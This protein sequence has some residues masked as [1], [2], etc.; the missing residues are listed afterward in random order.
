MAAYNIDKETLSQL[1]DPVQKKMNEA[2][3]R[4]L[5]ERL[6]DD[7][8]SDDIPLNEDTQP[9][10]EAVNYAL[11][12]F[13]DATGPL[14]VQLFQ[15]LHSPFSQF[16][17][18]VGH[19]D[20][21]NASNLIHP[22]LQNLSVIPTSRPDY[23]SKAAQKLDSELM[24]IR[25]RVATTE[26]DARQEQ[27][28]AADAFK[29]LANQQGDSVAKRANELL[30]E[31]D[32]LQ[33]STKEEQSKLVQDMAQL[34]DD[35]QERYGFTAEQVLGGAHELAATNEHNLAE[36]HG[37]WS[38]RSMWGAVAW[39]GL[40]QIIWLTPFAPDWEQWLDALRSV[41]I[42][43]S[44]VVIL[45]FIAKREG[46]VAFEHRER[47]EK[48]QSL[49]LQLKSWQ[50]YLNTLS[51]SVREELEKKITPRLFVGDTSAAV[52]SDS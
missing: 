13:G 40:A 42:I 9:I 38:R 46:R 17:Q 32:H 29:Q 24:E 27:R 35:L 12:I 21:G 34:L 10:F 45:L 4:D 11:M 33:S 39:A 44:P 2:G 37:K 6:L 1:P 41:P 51:E 30:G 23:S 14:T 25:Q 22:L 18:Y 48:L 8:N 36:L 19:R 50:P 5:L 26:S 15:N 7:L 20:W 31:F 47:H 43:G 52:S 49:A 3:L 28:E 16:A